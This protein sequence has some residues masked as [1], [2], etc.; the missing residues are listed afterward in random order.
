MLFD[1][2]APAFDDRAGVP[3][4]VARAVADALAELAGPVD[5]QRWLEVGAGT[6]GL[7][8]PLLRLPIRYT[9][10]DRSAAM[11]EVFRERVDAA[12]LAA[13]LRVTDG[14]ARWTADDASVDVIFSARALHHLDAEHAAVETRRVLAAPGGWL[15]L[16]RVRRPPESVKSV[17]RR[18]MRRML[19][20]QGFAGRSHEARA[21]AVFT[22]LERVGGRRI[23]PR[24]AARWTAPHRPADSI[25]SWEGKQGLAGIDV[26]ADVKAR[27]LANLRAWAAAEFG[28]VHQPREQEE[29]FELDAIRVPIG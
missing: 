28:D 16:G 29:A 14:N 26:P 9:G 11:L 24:V 1:D 13:E 23:E 4:H 17:L 21:G 10:F 2:Q 18:Q 20:A 6:G 7:S 27:V 3:E 25:A 15:V 5:G 22:A 12:G 19:Q 8:L